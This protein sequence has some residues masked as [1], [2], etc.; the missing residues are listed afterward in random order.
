MLI[1]PFEA[2]FPKLEAIPDTRDFILTAKENYKLFQAQGYFQAP[3]A[4][5][6]YA[7][8]ISKQGTDTVQCGL[9]A[10]VSVL[11]YIEEHIKKH[12]HTLVP[13]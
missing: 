8:Q 5:A 1:H 9:L 7:Y 11:D 2:T 3:K 10:S 13:K 6:M 12:E 4:S